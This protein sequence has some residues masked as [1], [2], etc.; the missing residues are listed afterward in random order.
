MMKRELFFDIGMFNQ[1]LE[2]AED[3]ELWLRI[4][5][6]YNTGYIDDPLIIKR[7]GDWDQLS[8][9]YKQ[10]EIFRIKA[11]LL[12]IKN[13]TFTDKNRILAEKELV[14]KCRIYANGCIKRGKTLEA[15]K[16]LKFI[17]KELQIPITLISIGPG[18]KETI[19]V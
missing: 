18:R 9:K 5:N 8:W 3:Y 12:N 6:K 10:I 14:R 2:I 11:L 7:A 13:N 4:C 16:Y 19:E 17:E 1:K 15:E